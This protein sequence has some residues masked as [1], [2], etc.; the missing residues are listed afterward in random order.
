M[1]ETTDI[2]SAKLIAARACVLGLIAFR[3]RFETVIADGKQDMTEALQMVLGGMDWTEQSGVRVYATQTEDHLFGTAPASWVDPTLRG[4]A[5]W[6]EESL[7]ALLWCLELAEAVPYDDGFDG[8]K[9]FRTLPFLSDSPF[10]TEE[11]MAPR[12]ELDAMLVGAKRRDSAEIQTERARAELW[13][14]RARQTQ[15]IADGSAARTEV[16]PGVADRV[17]RATAQGLARADDGDLLAFGKRYE[18]LETQELAIANSIATSR[19]RALNW[20]CG[21]ADDWDKVPLE[22]P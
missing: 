13:L 20:V 16:M 17:G 8:E 1:V 19:L 6:H 9:L 3:G 4:V 18:A 21:R 5:R 7:G 14:W 15:R 2:V 11:D 10:V 22:T 12:E